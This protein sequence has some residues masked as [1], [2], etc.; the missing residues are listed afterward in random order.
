MLGGPA[1]CLDADGGGYPDLRMGLLVG[2]HPGVH[3]S[4]VV[5][6]AL[7]AE[8][9]GVG[10]C[11]DN[12]VMRFL[13]SLA[14][15]YGRGVVGYALASA[16][17]H[18]AGDEPAVADHV[19]HGK[20]LG[21]PEGVVPDGQD[22]AQNDDLGLGGLAGEDGSSDVGHAL[23]TEGG[24]VV[25]VEHE[26]VEA[27]LLGVEL[28]VEIPVVERRADLGVVHLVADA[29]VGGLGSHEAGLVVLPGLLGEVS[30]KH[31]VSPAAW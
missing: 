26:A 1:H 4:V 13:E 25:L 7:P 23:H 17:A 29:E 31:D 18:E 12:E 6:L 16:A 27:H 8:G 28:F 9:S 5:V 11:L 10:P 24:A 20:L 22:I 19:Y 2:A 30:Y 21:E 15:E 3:V 14:V